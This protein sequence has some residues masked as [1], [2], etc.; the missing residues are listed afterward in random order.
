M[1]LFWVHDAVFPFSGPSWNLHAPFTLKLG[2]GRT[3][4]TEATVWDD[5]K[6]LA[7]WIRRSQIKDSRVEHG[8]LNAFRIELITT[9]YLEK[10]GQ[11][12]M[13]ILTSKIL[14][15]ELTCVSLSNSPPSASEFLMG[16]T[17]Q[18]TV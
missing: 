7:E 10:F 5:R 2:F 13:T 4:A 3:D 11:C 1:L 9:L 16:L 8:G 17:A 15:I 14:G 6:T 12:S 18:L